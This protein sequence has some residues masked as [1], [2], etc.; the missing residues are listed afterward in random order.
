MSFKQTSPIP[1]V[2]GGTNATSMATSTGIVNYDGTRL[3]TSSTAKIDS[4]NRQTNTAQPCFYA[5]L[6]SN[7]ANVTGDGTGYGITF[8]V[9]DFDQNSN[10]NTGTGLFTAPVTGKYWISASAYLQS[11][12]AAHT[13]G[14]LGF[15]INSAAI[16]FLSSDI[17]AA[18][19]R[20]GNNNYI[21]SCSKLISLNAS[22][23]VQVR[24][25]V[26]N[27]TKTVQVGGTTSTSAPSSTTFSGYLV[28]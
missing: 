24:V 8:D 27:S 20:D 1:V 23:T 7:Q 6:S 28:C 21:I 15:S 2:E 26:F 4:S 11:L 18:N 19:A 10:Y 9:A 5:H 13:I 3:V 12:G 22:D 25:N 17:N 14:T 16:V